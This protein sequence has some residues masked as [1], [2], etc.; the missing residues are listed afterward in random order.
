MNPRERPFVPSLGPLYSD[1]ALFALWDED[2]AE[3]CSIDHDRGRPL[4]PTGKETGG[5][6]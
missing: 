4:S 3:S 2:Q 6:S 5:N 1:N